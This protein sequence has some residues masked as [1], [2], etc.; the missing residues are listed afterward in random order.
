VERNKCKILVGNFKKRD[1]VTDGTMDGRIILK[2]ALKKQVY[3]LLGIL[4]YL[5]CVLAGRYTL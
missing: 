2:R 5:D 1:H 3:K 4:I